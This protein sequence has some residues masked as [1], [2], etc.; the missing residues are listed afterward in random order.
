MIST[1]KKSQEN[2]PKN[3]YEIKKET[4]IPVIEDKIEIKE[5][6]TPV[7]NNAPLRTRKKTSTTSE[8][9][10]NKKR[11]IDSLQEG[12]E[13]EN[14]KP[15]YIDISDQLISL[16]NKIITLYMDADEDEDTEI[17][18][19][20]L[21]KKREKLQ[22]EW[23][24]VKKL[25]TQIVSKTTPT[26]N[27]T[28][29]KTF[30]QEIES[31]KDDLPPPIIPIIKPRRSIDFSTPTSSSSYTPSPKI[32]TFSPDIEILPKTDIFSREEEDDIFEVERGLES[33]K[34]ALDTPL[35]ID[36]EKPTSYSN[37]FNNYPSNGSYFSS[38]T[39]NTTSDPIKNSSNYLKENKKITTIDSD[40]LMDIENESLYSW[41]NNVEKVMKEVFGINSFR[42]NQKEGK[43]NIYLLI[44]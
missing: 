42:P 39:S 1:L 8:L 17:Y 18:L 36:I 37:S 7:H 5:T 32:E 16:Q 29:C 43:N 25:E 14:K 11:K 2:T 10:I 19:K 40:D 30:S 28:N 34:K 22:K 9:N 33:F 31:P 26:T 20:S 27:N 12:E 24:E 41:T 44:L 15:K 23:E 21:L 38:F 4:I 3:H 35:I 13:E 6:T